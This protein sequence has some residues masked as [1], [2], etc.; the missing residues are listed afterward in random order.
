MPSSM[1]IGNTKWPVFPVSSFIRVF[2]RIQEDCS[3]GRQRN[4]QKIVM[5]IS[6]R[7]DEVCRFL[8]SKQLES[9]W[10]LT[11]K[12]DK[13]QQEQ[14]VLVSL[15]LYVFFESSSSQA[16]FLIRVHYFFDSSFPSLINL[17][18]TTT[19]LYYV[20]NCTAQ[21]RVDTTDD[22]AKTE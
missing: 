6:K 2:I 14:L 5:M 18:S 8:D 22:L 11:K 12:H 15:L 4:K 20:K 7:R 19:R 9:W 16:P 17:I 3:P 13:E 1:M 10:S 21:E